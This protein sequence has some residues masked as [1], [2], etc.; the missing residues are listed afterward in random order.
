MSRSNRYRLQRAAALLRA[1]AVI[2]HP[3]EAVWG[4]ACVPWDHS[5]VAKILG[6]KARD[7]AK[8]LVLVS[9]CVE[10]FAPV[11]ADLPEAAR[12]AVL[13]SWPGPHTWVV[14]DSDWAPQWVRGKFSSVAIRVTNHPLTVD[15]CRTANTCLVSTSANPAG[16][17]PARSQAQVR[18]YFGTELSYYLPGRTGSLSKPT[19]IRDALSGQLYRE[20]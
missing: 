16:L 1:G 15:L 2:S 4:L 14:P 11:L 10:R 3:T 12:K 5:A 8:G 6:M 13:A 17:P 9:D 19:E 18:R 7:P 20:A